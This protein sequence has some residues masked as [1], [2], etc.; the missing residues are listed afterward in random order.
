MLAL[1]V[2]EVQVGALASVLILTQF[3]STLLGG[4]FADRFGRKRVLVVF[5]ILC[6]G[7][8][9]FLYA[10]AQNPWY[11][12]AGRLING[13]VYVVLPSFECLFV[14]DVP[15]E[16]RTAVFGTLH[17][18]MAGASL[19]APLAGYLVAR[20]GIVPA[21]RWI[22]ASCMLSAIAMAVIRQFT[23]RETSMGQERMSATGGLPS[24][25]LLREYVGI[26]RAMARDRRMR[27]F[28]IVRN[29]GAFATIMWITYSTIYLTA[30]CGVG[31]AES[32]VAFLPFL[33]AL[34]TMGVILLAA[35][36]M[37]VERTFGNLIVGQGLWLVAA[38]CFVASP[39]GTPWFAALWAVINA[40]STTL[41]R[42]AE[43]GYWANIVGDRERAQ[44]F[45]ASSALTSLVTLPAG[46]LAGA[47]YTLFPRGPFLL[48]MALQAA[49]LGLILTL[50]SKE[51]K[52]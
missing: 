19:L 30:P 50:R 49:A 2:S 14:E 22:M 28:M 40:L 10:V 36:R 8:P 4:Y 31:L 32:S 13:F 3:I 39:A 33:S 20:I 5:D 6:W 11:F 1:G 24:W 37:R 27:T 52:E 23:M 21:G 18:L 25:A 29:L 17:F 42:P 7:V 43:R 48:G 9:M 47:L 41:F 38:L 34:V 46:P 35:E 51:E 45:S 15:V 44:V 16:R 12:L 26:I